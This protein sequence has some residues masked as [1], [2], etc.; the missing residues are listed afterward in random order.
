LKR[1]DPRTDCEMATRLNKE[2]FRVFQVFQSVL[3]FQ[4]MS[5]MN[6]FSAA[7]KTREL[8]SNKDTNTSQKRREGDEMK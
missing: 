6:F 3:W 2:C 7:V 1:D 4:E 8:S 5:V